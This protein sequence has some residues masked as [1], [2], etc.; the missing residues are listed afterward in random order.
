MKYT[1]KKTL[2]TFEM[3]MTGHLRAASLMNEMQ[4]AA[5]AHAEILGR[6]RTWC[7]ETGHAWVVLYYLVEIDELPHE[8][9]IVNI[10]TW[11][12]GTDGLRAMRE[13]VITDAADGRTLVR[14]TTQWVIIDAARRMPVR[15]GDIMADWEIVDERAVNRPFDKFP[16]FGAGTAI[17][18]VPRFDEVDVNGHINNAV[19]ATW[20]TESLGFDFRATHTPR[21]ID[22]NFVHEIPAGTSAV[23]IESKLDGDI[24]HH[25]IRSDDTIN[26]RV[27]C[28]WKAVNK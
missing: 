15:L 22:I 28:R 13:F 10:T 26:A 14:A 1:I 2:T 17:T 24:S 20:A 4:A 19:Y 16:E 27:I 3:D 21:E 7:T 6:G 23:I 18:I 11:P 5:D 25:T 8:N 12:S 9:H